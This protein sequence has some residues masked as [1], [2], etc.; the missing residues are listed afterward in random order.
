GGTNFHAVL[1]EYIPGRLNGNGKRSVAVTAPPP[2]VAEKSASVTT[3]AAPPSPAVAVTAPPPVVAEKSVTMTTV[4]PPSPAA[5]SCKAP[6][7]GALVI[8]D[9]SDVALIERLQ[10]VQKDAAAGRVPA[11]AAPAESD[12]RAPERLV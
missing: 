6:L 2:F 4:T 8:G 9:I 3:A 12:L 10:A 11:P 5:V 1:E 7:R